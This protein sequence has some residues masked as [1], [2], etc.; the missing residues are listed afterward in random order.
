M[1]ERW[2]YGAMAAALAAVA[3]AGCTT[4]AAPDA[5]AQREPEPPAVVDLRGYRIDVR[6]GQGFE[7]RLPGNPSTGYRWVLVDPVP[8]Q[9]RQVGVARVDRLGS[10]AGVGAPAQEVFTFEAAQPGLSSLAFEYRRAWDAASVPPAQ[11][12]RYRLEVR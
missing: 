11:R 3:L 12:T 7:V 10:D 1:G 9:A 5:T 8:P 6:V 4:P 2:R